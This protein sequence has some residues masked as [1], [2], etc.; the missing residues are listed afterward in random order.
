MSPSRVLRIDDLY[1]H[2]WFF[3][4]DLFFIVVAFI[5]YSQLITYTY[6]S[7]ANFVKLVS[8]YA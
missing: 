8:A 2:D 1:N 6:H 4:V 5:F 7:G 3:L